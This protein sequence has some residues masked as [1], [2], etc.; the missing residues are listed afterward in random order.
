MSAFFQLLIVSFLPRILWSMNWGG[1]LGIS[2]TFQN[3][4]QTHKCPFDSS[5]EVGDCINFP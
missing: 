5:K 4:R 3:P 2:P 1:Q